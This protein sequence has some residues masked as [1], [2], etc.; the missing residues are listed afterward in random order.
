MKTL[1]VLKTFVLVMA[2]SLAATT[3]HAQKKG[4]MAVGGHLAIGAGDDIT[5]VGI[6]AKF[7]YNVIDPL[8]LEGSFT[9]FFK[10]D[11]VSMWDFSA[12]AHWLFPITDKFI[13][14]P[15]GGIGILG[16]KVNIPEVSY[17]GITIG[18][19]ASESYFALNLGGGAE[20]LITDNLSANF[21]FKYKIADWDRALFTFGVNYKF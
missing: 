3:V 1:N 8:R 4:D 16:V 14:Y 21:E 11:Y 9:Y 18:G 7:Q 19:S 20:Y 10:K 17:G 2:V 12:N 13:L 5:N 6:G 15:I